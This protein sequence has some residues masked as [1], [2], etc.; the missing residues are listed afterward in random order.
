MDYDEPETEIEENI[1]ILYDIPLLDE[2]YELLMKINNSLL[3][4]KL[5]KT[6]IIDG[7]FYKRRYNLEDINK[8]LH[9]TF[10]RI[11]DAFNFFDNLL[12]GKKINLIKSNEDIINLNFQNT[13]QNIETNVEIEKV[14]LTNYEMNFIFLKEINSLKNKLNLSEEKI[15]EKDN[16]INDLKEKMEQ[17]KQEQETKINEIE[18]KY[19]KK[20][21]DIENLINPIIEKENER[22]EIIKFNKLNDNVNLVND[23]TEIDVENM[24]IEK[25]IANNL[26]IKWMKSVAVY[27]IIRNNEANYEIAYPENLNIKIYNILS[28]KKI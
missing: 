28:N 11:K 19:E 7:Y 26:N 5:Q 14:K 6:N 4:F 9:T 27:K 20:I 1:E 13:T 16:K 3:E 15:K 18:N 17:L 8:L 21:S 2:E 22:N 23:F 25:N 10:E 12:K 24:R